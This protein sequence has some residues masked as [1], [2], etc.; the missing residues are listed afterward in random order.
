MT[1]GHPLF[2][3]IVLVAAGCTARNPLFDPD[4]DA[5]SAEASGMSGGDSGTT[6]GVLPGPDTRDGSTG[7]PDRPL[8]DGSTSDD[9]KG[10]SSGS[11]ESSAS[12]SDAVSESST[13]EPADCDPLEL[14]DVTCSD[15]D[16]GLTG[17]V[18]CTAAGDYDLRSCSD[19]NPCNINSPDEGAYVDGAC[20]L[21][22][23]SGGCDI[24]FDVPAFCA[25]HGATGSHGW[26]GG[27]HWNPQRANAIAL[28]LGLPY[29]G[30]TQ[31]TVGFA[32]VDGEAGTL[33]LSA[34]TL[35]DDE[36]VG[37]TNWGICGNLED[38]RNL[39][40]CTPA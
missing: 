21:V 36:F 14:V 3:A 29:V 13:G 31:T 19:Q 15:F 11:A 17:E 35:M 1:R 7:D 12:T 2:T 34:A 16:A 39:I 6:G 32:F 4:G 30:T 40:Y 8:P 10:S 18:H 25:S 33:N 23:P 22:V 26:I 28:Q 24:H 38:M 5:G 20:W 27:L 37:Y 9:G